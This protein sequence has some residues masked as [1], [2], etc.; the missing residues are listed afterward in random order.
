MENRSKQYRIKLEVREKEIGSINF[1]PD[2]DVSLNNTTIKEINRSDVEKMVTKYSYIKSMPNFNKFYFGIYFKINNVDYLGGVLIYSVDYENNKNVW[3]KYS[4]KD[5]ILG[6]EIGVTEWWVPINTASFFISRANKIIKNKSKYRVITD[7]LDPKVMDIGAIYQSLNW[8]Y[9]GNMK[10]DN[11]ERFK[12]VLNEKVYS[13]NDFEEKFNV[14]G[15]NEIIKNF[16]NSSFINDL[17]KRRYITFLGSK[18]ENKKYKNEIS[19]IIKNYPTKNDLIKLLGEQSYII[20]KMSNPF[21]NKVYIG[22]TVRML[23]NRVDAFRRGKFTNEHLSEAFNSYGF[24]NFI[25]EIIELCDDVTQL[26]DRE[27]YWINYYKST[28]RE[29][30][31]NI[32]GGGK[33]SNLSEET[34]LKLSESH[35]GKKQS[36]EWVTKRFP[37][38][39]SED[40]KRWGRPKTE[41]QKQYLSDISKGE[42]GF[43]FGKEKP[44]ELIDKIKATKAKQKDQILENNTQKMG[45]GKY[46]KITGELLESYLSMSQASTKLGICYK[47]IYNRCHGITPQKGDFILKLLTND[48]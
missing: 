18:K 23:S 14:K 36:H 10:N 43:W 38:K 40:A 1:N 16:P 46:N 30:G 12:V 39:G 20:Y 32:E 15:K 37:E 7:A 33:R 9:I 28:N 5:K 13:S 6:L 29:F 3:D 47:T 26:D 42:K 27:K 31:Y 17:R 41:E 35:K 22:Q 21:N 19:D 24:G 2:L 4:F 48:K 44:Q 34:K 8:L 25:F 45:V 11:S